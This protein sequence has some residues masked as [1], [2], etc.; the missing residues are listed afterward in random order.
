MSAAQ[1]GA[2]LPGPAPA[3]LR[4]S[5]LWWGIGWAFI[6]LVVYGSLQAPDGPDIPFLVSDKLV[7]FGAYWLMTIW[8]AGVLH[9]RRYPW[10]ALGLLA[11][12]GGIEL[13]QG[14]MGFGRDADWRDMVANTLGVF[15]ALGVAYAGLGSWMVVIERRLSPSAS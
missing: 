3:K 7:H 2:V 9:R 6:A 1:G 13:L 15:T 10:L 4:Y 5:K 11:L 14:A 12:G 8:F